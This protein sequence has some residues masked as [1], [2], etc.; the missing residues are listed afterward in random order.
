MTADTIIDGWLHTGDVGVL[1]SEGY[2]KITGRVK[3]MYKTSKGEY[4]APA[5]IEFGFADNSFIDQICVAGQSLPQ[6]VA[7]IVL[8]EAAQKVDRTE[9]E[10]SLHDTL[11]ALNPNLKSY[12]RI[13]KIIVMSEPWTVDNNMLTPTMKIKRNVIEKQ[14]APHLE[15]W[16]ERKETVIWL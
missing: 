8:S 6:P 1:D 5:Q 4:I 3:E 13:K 15:D 2:L 11:K 7:L 12:E 16:Y 9:A 10:Q 14:F